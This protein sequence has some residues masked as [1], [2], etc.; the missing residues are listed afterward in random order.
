MRRDMAGRYACAELL[1]TDRGHGL[2]NRPGTWF[3]GSRRMGV[4]GGPPMPWRD[5]TKMLERMRFVVDAEKDLFTMTELC[6]RYGISR[7]TG[8]KWIGRF[9]EGGLDCLEDRSRAPVH[10]PHRTPAEVVELLAGGAASASVLR[11]AE[12]DPLVGAAASEACPAGVQHGYGDP[13]ESRFGQAPPT[14][15]TS[16]FTE[17]LS[18][19]GF[20]SQPR[21]D[22]RLQR[23]VQNSRRR[24][25]LP[26]DCCRQL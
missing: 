18:D 5:T 3:T 23:S 2:Q 17:P 24:L 12:A 22:G 19:G 9:R 16:F 4:G 25:L 14:P 6:G 8:H 10:C 1:G 13:Q 7:V 15:S 26:A 21:L 20:Q 11:G